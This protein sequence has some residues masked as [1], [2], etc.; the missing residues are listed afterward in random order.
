MTNLVTHMLSH[1][2]I[3]FLV[4]IAFVYGGVSRQWWV[5]VPVGP[6]RALL[7][8]WY[9]RRR[10]LP[11]WTRS[12]ALACLAFNGAMVTAHVPV[13]F[14]YCMGREWAMQWLMDMGFFVSGLWF[15]HFLVPSTPRRVTTSLKWQ[16]ILVG[17]TVLEMLFLAMSMS[18]FTRSAWYEAGAIA[19]GMT[20]TVGFDFHHQQLSAGILWVCGD[21]WAV[22]LAVVIV[23]RVMKRDGS[24]LSFLERQVAVG[25]P[26]RGGSA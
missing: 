1:V 25:G 22:P 9:V 4:P 6:R 13:I 11:A 15:F 24:L 23:R 14:N 12:P 18:I 20:T 8:W 26:S 21:F 16:A 3:M 5:L 7:R 17:A 10:R 2:V 19:M